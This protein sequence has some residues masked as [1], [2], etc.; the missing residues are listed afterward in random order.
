MHTHM[1]THTHIHMYTHMH[2]HMYTN[3]HAHFHTHTLTR[4]L[5]Q[6]WS[7]QDWLESEKKSLGLQC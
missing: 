2:T 5:I 3:T 6:G 7:L 4:A 1:Y